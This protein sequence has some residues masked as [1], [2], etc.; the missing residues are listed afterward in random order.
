LDAQ[1]DNTGAAVTEDS[2]V[3]SRR[4]KEEQRLARLKARILEQLKAHGATNDKMI[5]PDVRRD[6]S[7]V[8]DLKGSYAVEVS[9]PGAVADLIA[10][11]PKCEGE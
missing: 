8:V 3:E 11:P 1:S 5:H 4:R 6:M 9:Q 10:R 2:K 7:K